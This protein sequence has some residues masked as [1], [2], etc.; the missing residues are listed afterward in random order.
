M[1]TIFTRILEGEIPARFVYTDSACA[2][3]L[4]VRPLARGHCLV[5]PRKEVDQWTDLSAGEAAHL[6]EVA[7]AI[8]NVQ[9]RLLSPTR[10]GLMIAGFEVPHA[11]V[12]VVPLDSMANLDFALADASPDPEDLDWL[13]TRIAEG[14][15]AAGHEGAAT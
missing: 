7:H 1:P 9:M 12:H 4:D 14:L 13:R 2:A 3:F 11:H 6:T 8:G 10:I 5:V 15:E